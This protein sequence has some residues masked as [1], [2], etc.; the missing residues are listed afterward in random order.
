MKQ[1][2]CITIVFFFINAKSQKKQIIDTLLVLND[3]IVVY[4]DK[5][6]E[7]LKM[8]NF[9]GVLN[10]SLD[11]LMR[12]EFGD[13]ISHS[14]DNSEPYTMNNDL[15]T[16]KD[17]IWLCVTDEKHP[18]FC[19]P[20]KGKTNSRF[21]PRG[22]RYHRGIDLGFN[23]GDSI[24]CAF[25]GI[26][27]Y[28]R[29]NYGGYGNLVIIRH[30]NGLETF[31]A[32]LKKINVSVNQELCASAYIG[33]GGSTGNVSGPHLHFEVRFYGNAIDP[34]LIFDFKTKHLHSENLFIHKNSFSY[35]KKYGRIYSSTPSFHT[36]EKGDTLYDLALKYGLSI[37]KI[38]K[39]NEIKSSKIL[40]IGEKIRI[41]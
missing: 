26:V 17:S 25:D 5:S 7:Y 35:A 39:L 16:L 9:D 37:N 31:Y 6:W 11:Q 21:G 22:K 38:C 19:F 32:H 4:S 40:K 15:S 10:P 2:L 13:K 18:E 14:W 24:F 36:I 29:Y 33:K 30:Y 41:Q 23:N 28:A 27:R 20:S 8:L 3:S 34:E 1:L 12:K